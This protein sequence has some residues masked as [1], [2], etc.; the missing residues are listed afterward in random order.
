MISSTAARRS[1]CDGRSRLGR[2][3]GV[4]DRTVISGESRLLTGTPH[5]PHLRR[6]RS[7]QC[8]PRS[9]KQWVRTAPGDL[10]PRSSASRLAWTCLAPALSLSGA[11][12]TRQGRL[13][14]RLRRRPLTGP[15]YSPGVRSYREPGANRTPLG[16]AHPSHGP[17]PNRKDVGLSDQ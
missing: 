7:G 12:R 8:C 1:A 13:R 5:E 6:A 3:R 10:V 15:A 9:P 16:R 2:A 11:S 17:L 14:R 4:P